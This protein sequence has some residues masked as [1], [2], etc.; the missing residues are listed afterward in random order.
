ME[1]DN[2][3]NKISKMLDEK[4]KKLDENSLKMVG[5]LNEQNA[6]LQEEIRGLEE[7]MTNIVNIQQNEKP[8]GQKRKLIDA[9]VGQNSGKKV[10]NWGQKK[11]KLKNNF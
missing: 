5:L 10:E 4:K 7:Q 2:Y 6:K 9:Q 11:R 8:S 1:Q 3:Q